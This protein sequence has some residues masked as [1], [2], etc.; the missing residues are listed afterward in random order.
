MF[1]KLIVRFLPF[2]VGTV[3]TKTIADP[4]KCFQELISEELQILLWDRPCL[5]LIFID[6]SYQAFLFLQGKLL[7][8]V[9]K[10]L[11]FPVNK[12]KKLLDPPF[13]EWIQ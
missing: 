8:S 2:L 12:F 11:I 3:G 7:E 1:L 6:S 10:R 13:A 5:E 4:E 9:W